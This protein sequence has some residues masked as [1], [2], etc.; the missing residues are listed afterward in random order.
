MNQTVIVF[1]KQPQPGHVKTRLA[2][3][4]GDI[5]AADIAL[6]LARRT[7]DACLK[8]G[9][10]VEVWQTPRLDDTFAT[11][12]IDAIRLQRK[13][14]LGQRMGYAI[15]ET[16]KRCSSVVL[17]GTDCPGIDSTY[18]VQAFARLED[19]DAV[20]SPAEDGG[21]GLIGMRRYPEGFFSGIEWSTPEVYRKVCDRLDLYFEQWG[22]LPLLWD[23]DRPFD[24]LRYEVLGEG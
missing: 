22:R 2:A 11:R 9:V 14:D 10:R 4:V 20:V 1:C 18:V 7:I 17:M 15:D 19:F 23:V 13:G 5:E 16:L 3:Q 8:L 12:G 21:F 24:L 6:K